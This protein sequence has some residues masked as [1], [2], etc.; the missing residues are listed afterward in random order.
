MLDPGC[1]SQLQFW[2]RGQTNHRKTLHHKFIE[3]YFDKSSR[4]HFVGICSGR[5]PMSHPE[6][7][8][9][10]VPIMCRDSDRACIA[11]V[12]HGGIGYTAQTHALAFGI[13][14][15]ARARVSSEYVCGVARSRRWNSMSIQYSINHKF[16]RLRNESVWIGIKLLYGVTSCSDGS[17]FRC[18]TADTHTPHLL[19]YARLN[20]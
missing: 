16:V 2:L 8:L 19:S 9:W 10:H 5:I 14:P 18:H 3:Y 6:T 15:Y 7:R 17:F 13:T 11:Y 12:M 20:A 4:E 1:V